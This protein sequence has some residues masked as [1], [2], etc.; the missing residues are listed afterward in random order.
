[1]TVVTA[2]SPDELRDIRAGVRVVPDIA[3]LI[4]G[5]EFN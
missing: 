3:A 5:Y 1:M 2:C 4:P